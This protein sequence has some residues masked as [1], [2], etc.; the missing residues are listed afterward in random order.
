MK[1]IR[2]GI[3]GGRVIEESSMKKHKRKKIHIENQRKMDERMKQSEEEFDEI[4]WDRY[5][6]GR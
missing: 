1:K 5:F 3:C 2:C 6:F 4:M